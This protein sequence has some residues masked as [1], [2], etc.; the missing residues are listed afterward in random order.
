MKPCTMRGPEIGKKYQRVVQ[1]L[2]NQLNVVVGAHTMG[3]RNKWHT[4]A[5]HSLL[6]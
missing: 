5:G 1:N 2:Y 6:G 4:T 3:Y